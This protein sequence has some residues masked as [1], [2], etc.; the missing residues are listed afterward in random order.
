M[1]DAKKL[2]PIFR[3]EKGLVYLNTAASAQK[4]D[5]VIDGMAGFMRE[6][7][8]N[9]HRGL[10]PL[11]MRANRIYDEARARAARFINAEPDEIVFA[12]N[13]TEAINLAASQLRP[14]D[15]VITTEAEHHSNMLPWMKSGAKVKFMPIFGN[16]EPDYG[17]LEKNIAGAR[18]VAMSGQSNVLGLRND[19]GRAAAIAHSAGA[20]ILVDAAQMIVHHGLDVCASDIDFAAFSGHKIYG[21]TGIGVL[22]G[23]RAL[24][25]SM[26][27]WQVGGDT[28]E[29]ASLEGAKYLAP[30]MRFEAG[31]QPLAEAHG[32]ALAMD[33]MNE[34]GINRIERASAELSGY[35]RALLSEIKGI[36]II[37]HPE[38]NGI[39]TFAADGI[40]PFDIG[41]MLGAKNICAR[42]GLH[43]AEPLHKRLGIE[44]SVRISIGLYNDKPD[45]DAFAK[46]LREV[47]H[48]LA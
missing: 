36:R 40:S 44:G 16:G 20:K 10:Y 25:E 38:S 35:A 28:I 32:L 8:A 18:I 30:P 24:L 22:Y 12:K 33:F 1:N 27:P 19:I 15:T 14:G 7:Y 37:S 17:W 6:N 39:I 42:A 48:A 29:T 34:F 13:A 11:A 21:P 9:I 4:P 43:C 45:I 26:E 5:L 41:A 3:N 46:G 2:F 31:T 47:L 23:R